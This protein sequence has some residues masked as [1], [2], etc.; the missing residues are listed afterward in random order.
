MRK[1]LAIA[2]ALAG[3]DPINAQAQQGLADAYAAT[4]VPRS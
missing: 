4:A 1:S 3:P 2:Q